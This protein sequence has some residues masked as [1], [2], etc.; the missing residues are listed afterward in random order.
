MRKK[1]IFTGFLLALILPAILVINLYKTNTVDVINKK[2]DMTQ[3]SHIT[4][5]SGSDNYCGEAGETIGALVKKDG[6]MEFDKKP[7]NQDFQ[8][9]DNEKTAAEEKQNFPPNKSHGETKDIKSS[10]KESP[11]KHFDDSKEMQTITLSIDCRTILGNMDR[12]NKDKLDILPRDGI[13]FPQTKVEF[14][15]GDSAF[16]ILVKVLRENRLH[17]DF[18]HTPALDSS[19][20]KGIGNIYE[21]DCGELSGWLYMVNG[22]L[23]SYGSSNYMPSAGDTVEWRYSCDLGSDLNDE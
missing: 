2:Y 9:K 12:L 14:E 17:I 22:Q 3:Q 15:E 10:D 13:I 7:E 20:I 1:I 11:S 19:Y 18:V 23:M 6:E 21:F 16:D 8:V 4:P 5:M